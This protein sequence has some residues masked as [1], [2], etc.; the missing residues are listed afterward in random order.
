MKIKRWL[1]VLLSMLLCVGLMP[2]MAFAAEEY[3]V[4]AVGVWITSD[5]ADDVLGDGGSVVYEPENNTLT[6]TDATLTSN[7]YCNTG[8]ALNIVVNGTNTMN[9][10]GNIATGISNFG[11]HPINISG[12]GKLT[13]TVAI[14]DGNAISGNNVV[15]DGTE[16][17]LHTSGSALKGYPLTLQNGA[18]VTAVLSEGSASVAV[19]GGDIKIIG[20]TLT[21]TSPLG[22]SIFADSLEIENSTVTATG[23][24][25]MMSWGDITVTDSTVNAKSTADWGIWSNGNLTIKGKS[26]VTAT[27]SIAALGAAGSFTLEP[28]EGELIDVFAGTDQDNAPA[29]EESPLSQTTDLSSYGN[30]N[31]KYFHSASHQHVITLVAKA[32][33]TCT[34]EGKEAYYTCAACGK[35]FEDEAGKTE[36]VDLENYGVIEAKGHT[37]TKHDKVE[38]TCTEPGNVEYWHCETCGKNFADEA[39]RQEL[40]SVEIPALGHNAVKTEA[41]APTATEPGNIEYW[42]CERCGKY[43]KDEALTQE[44]TQEQTVLA[45]TGVTDVPQTADESNIALWIVMVFCSGAALLAMTFKRAGK[46]G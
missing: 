44:I 6:L 25:P 22:N 9:C 5:N 21:A 41:K 33:P 37:M 15:I 8:S 1:S 29:I 40:S 28:P 42:Y 20:S 35:Y 26:N 2:T 39:G 7:I 46:R 13:I 36:I 24:Y 11:N 3:H 43:F 4:L 17:E 34:T 30:Q 31:I 12:E 23:Y 14:T 27:G 16:L 18:D 10:T 19:D 45:A 38:A 32:E